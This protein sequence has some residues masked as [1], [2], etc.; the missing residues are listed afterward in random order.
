MR[1][2][3]S[4]EIRS[5]PESAPGS[6]QFSIGELTGRLSAFHHLAAIFVERVVDDPLGGVLLEIVL[7][8]EMPKP[9]GDGFEAGS[10]GLAIKRVVGVGAVDDPPEQH[11][12][13]I[14]RQLV[15]LQ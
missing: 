4:P 3:R 11:K 2:S 12:R 7:V 14:A 10:L 6:C 5:T 1:R 8:A 13:R 9:F 15:L